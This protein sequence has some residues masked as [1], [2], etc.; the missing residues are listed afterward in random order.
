MKEFKD[1]EFKPIF[2][3][4]GIQAIM[5]FDND[6]GCSVVR[7]Y[8]SYGNKDGLYE[9]AVIKKYEESFV[10]VYNTVVTDDVEGFLSEEM[11]TG[12]MLDIQ[13]L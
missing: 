2:N 7:H 8:F 13:S 12:L 5:F 9:L 1:L 10:L 4:T 11:V 3:N 6:Y